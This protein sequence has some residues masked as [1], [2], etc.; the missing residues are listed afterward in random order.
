MNTMIYKIKTYLR[1]AYNISFFKSRDDI[2][3]MKSIINDD[4]GNMFFISN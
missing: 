4:L 1:Q 2:R 3:L